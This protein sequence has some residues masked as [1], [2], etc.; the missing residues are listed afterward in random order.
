MLAHAAGNLLQ[1]SARCQSGADAASH[2]GIYPFTGG[3]RLIQR[4][5]VTEGQTAALAHP[6]AGAGYPRRPAAGREDRPAACYPLGL[7]GLLLVWAYS[8]P[9]LRLMA[10]LG[11]PVV[12]GAWFL[13]VLGSDYVQRRQ[14]FIIPASA[15]LSFALLVA[16]LLLISSCPRRRCRRARGQAHPGRASGAAGRGLGLLLGLVLAAHGWLAAS[17]W[18]LIPPATGAVGAG[19]PAPVMAT[20]SLLPGSGRISP[21]A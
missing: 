9:P 15:A 13:V 21:S 4:G 2:Q 19:V 11:E 5:L 14:F 1:R 16:A 12:A 10:R 7:A 3:S 6:A 8:A 17:V 18:L 20:T